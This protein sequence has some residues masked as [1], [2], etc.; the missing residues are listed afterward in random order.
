MV[1]STPSRQR[2]PPCKTTKE[3][4][5]EAADAA[6]L[7]YLLTPASTTL[8]RQTRAPQ[9]PHTRQ[10]AC[11]CRQ[12]PSPHATVRPQVPPTASH[13]MSPLRT[14]AATTDGP[15]L[16]PRPLG[17][18]GSRAP[19]HP[20]PPLRGPQPPPPRA[21]RGPSRTPPCQPPQL[22]RSTH[23]HPPGPPGRV[24]RGGRGGP[25]MDHSRGHGQHTPAPPQPTLTPQQGRLERGGPPHPPRP[26]PPP[27]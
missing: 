13:C 23:R 7:T 27:P 16:Q 24:L 14:P 2:R 20:L 25:C 9:A 26:I 10:P 1:E 19:P 15:A 5:D 3:E 22:L 18:P 6:A 11:A 17:L 8:A 21:A 12:P 4:S